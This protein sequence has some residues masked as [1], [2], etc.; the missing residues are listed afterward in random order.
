[1]LLILMLRGVRIVIRFIIKLFLR[2]KG[3]LGHDSPNLKS[4]EKVTNGRSSLKLNICLFL[5]FFFHEN[6]GLN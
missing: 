5:F 2:Y 6:Y 1:M 3:T 4:K